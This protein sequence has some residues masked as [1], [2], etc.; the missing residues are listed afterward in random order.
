MRTY[1]VVPIHYDFSSLRPLE[2]LD[3]QD[4]L[5]VNPNHQ[6]DESDEYEQVPEQTD[7]TVH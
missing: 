5:F 7:G 1:L 6:R 3:A 2:T 4:L